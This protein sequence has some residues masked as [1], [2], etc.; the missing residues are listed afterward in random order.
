MA[1]STHKSGEGQKLMLGI[2]QREE[3]IRES[4]R[5]QRLRVPSDNGAALQLRA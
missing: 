3:Q 2:Q 1:R 5:G 4:G